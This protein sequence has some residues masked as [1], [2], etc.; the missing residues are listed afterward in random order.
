MPTYALTC[1][2][3]GNRFEIFLMRIIRDA[4]KV[5]P[6]CGSSSVSTGVGGG[7]LGTKAGS[8]SSCGPIG[9]YS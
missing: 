5:C 7:V 6:K 8:V 1:A 3:C 4:D 9:G 2:E